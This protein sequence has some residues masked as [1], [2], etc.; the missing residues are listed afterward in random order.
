MLQTPHGA[1]RC[2]ILRVLVRLVSERVGGGAE[3]P[4]GSLSDH[5]GCPANALRFAKVRSGLVV[6]ELLLDDLCSDGDDM[7]PSPEA[8]HTQGLQRGDDIF[9]L[10]ACQCAYLAYGEWLVA[11]LFQCGEE[12]VGPVGAVRQ[13]AQVRERFLRGA[14]SVLDL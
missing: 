5:L 2:N 4:L 14:H 10:D 11:V 13:L 7:L 12:H 6:C 3:S 1:I 8:N 9:H